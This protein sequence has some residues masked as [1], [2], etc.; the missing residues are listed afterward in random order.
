MPDSGY[1]KLPK[2]AVC[3][4]DNVAAPDV[5]GLPQLSDVGCWIPVVD[6]QE[7]EEA[8]QT[9]LVE[10]PVRPDQFEAVFQEALQQDALLPS[11]L[12]V[13]QRSQKVGDRAQL[14]RT[15]GRIRAECCDPSKILVSSVNSKICS[16]KLPCQRP[17]EKSDGLQRAAGWISLSGCQRNRVQLKS[18]CPV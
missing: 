12:A 7:I 1:Q 5:F 15:S 11:L 16:D 9:A 4:E 8:G 13:R 3:A 10:Y 2:P 6:R 18:R 14:R 17:Q